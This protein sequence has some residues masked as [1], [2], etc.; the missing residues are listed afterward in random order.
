MNNLWWTNL[1]V[2]AK[3]QINTSQPCANFI[4]IC[5]Y[6]NKGKI[7]GDLWM[8]STSHNESSFLKQLHFFVNSTYILTIKRWYPTYILVRKNMEIHWILTFQNSLLPLM[9]IKS[10][11]LW[12]SNNFIGL[13]KNN[14]YKFFNRNLSVMHQ[15]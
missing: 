14:A 9:L 6:L 10:T 1:I 8:S 12:N 15:I 4:K 3:L 2:S 11:S 7:E 13:W 5:I